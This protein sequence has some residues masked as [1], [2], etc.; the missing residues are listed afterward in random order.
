MLIIF[1]TH[2]I[3]EQIF[4]NAH[5]RMQK[6][7]CGRRY[8]GDYSIDSG[9]M[10]RVLKNVSD[11]SRKVICANFACWIAIFEGNWQHYELKCIC[12][13]KLF[14]LGEDQTE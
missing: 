4:Q 11:T 7:R 6:H 8:S 1:L 5:K 14:I 9:K 13:P 10:C 2:A 3:Y 12:E